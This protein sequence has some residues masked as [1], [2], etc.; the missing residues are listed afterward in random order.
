MDK[1]RYLKK[2]GV[3]FNLK[4]E[5][6]LSDSNEEYDEPKT[7]EFIKDQ[8]EQLGL[9]VFLCEQNEHLFDNLSNLNIDFAINISE[10]LGKTRARES[11]VPCMLES[12]GIPYYGSDPLSLGITL[13]KYLTSI[14]L[15]NFGIPVAKAIMVNDLDA[16]KEPS[17]GFSKRYIVKPRWEGSS[18]GIFS[19]SLVSSFKD[20]KKKVKYI[21]DICKQPVIIEEFL[22]GDEITVGLFGND[23]PKIL[24]MM[25][26]SEVNSKGDFIYSIENKRD[27]REKIKYEKVEGK[28]S[29]EVI[30]KIEEYALKAFKALELRDIARI[31]FRLDSKKN[32]KIIDINPLLGLSPEYSDLMLMSKL[33]K[34][35]FSD[36]VKTIF[37]ISFKR[38]GF[39]V[40]NG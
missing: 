27:W 1:S 12:L 3:C 9:K 8:L 10:G 20:C 6:S 33:Y 26:I 13:D 24:G 31:D 2:V 38:C 32:P 7:I 37:K 4:R 39:I 21:L 16:F 17:L 5:G 22:D 29:P 40:N 11:Q 30:Y 18:I 35:N 28:I 36:V 19:D 15:S 23:K 25:K 14:L 34:K